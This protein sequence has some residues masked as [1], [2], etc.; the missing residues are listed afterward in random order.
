MI[1][2]EQV[3]YCANELPA[4]LVPVLRSHGM[5]R[6]SRCLSEVKVTY[7]QPLDKPSAFVYRP[8]HEVSDDSKEAPSE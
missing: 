7:E 3:I 5:V 4:Q 6:C 8:T 2:T 1:Y